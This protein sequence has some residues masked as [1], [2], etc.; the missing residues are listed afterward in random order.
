MR[1]MMMT[2]PAGGARE[3]LNF[4]L[5]C[6][7]RSISFKKQSRQYKNQNKIKTTKTEIRH[8]TPL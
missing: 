2:G 7:K 1:M 6:P 3:Y 5:T 4:K 8:G